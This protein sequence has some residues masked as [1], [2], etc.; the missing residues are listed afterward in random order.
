ME[1]PR[2][3]NCPFDR[4]VSGGGLWPSL[5]VYP[6]HDGHDPQDGRYDRQ[7]GLYVVSSVSAF[8]GEPQLCYGASLGSI[9]LTGFV[10][11]SCPADSVEGVFYSFPSGFYLAV[12]FH[13]VDIFFHQYLSKNRQSSA[14]AR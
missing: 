8:D 10:A 3:S 6:P 4:F 5:F 1:L 11:E 7:S 13:R 12:F 9:F 2:R 14:L